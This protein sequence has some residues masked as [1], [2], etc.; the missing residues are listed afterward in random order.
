MQYAVCHS[1]AVRV[2]CKRQGV[3]LKAHPKQAHQLKTSRFTPSRFTSV[4]RGRRGRRTPPPCLATCRPRARPASHLQVSAGTAVA[5]LRG[6]APGK[7][8]V[9][10]S[11]SASAPVSRRSWGAAWAWWP[12]PSVVSIGSDESLQ[13]CM[14]RGLAPENSNTWAHARAQ[15]T[16]LVL[17]K[18]SVDLF[19][20]RIDSTMAASF[21]LRKKEVP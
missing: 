6:A 10:R 5:T 17:G 1:V 3:K 8:T 15:N 21:S 19:Q 2:V 7:D 14:G 13:F 9:H 18:I 12:D 4:A 11:R 16:A 20:P